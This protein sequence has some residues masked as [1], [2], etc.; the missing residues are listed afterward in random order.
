MTADDAEPFRNK[1]TEE[2][3]HAE[4]LVREGISTFHE[5]ADDAILARDEAA[6]EEADAEP[7]VQIVSRVSYLSMTR[8]LSMTR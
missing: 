7:G 1:V 5:V 8:I 6:E 3:A 4:P 2:M